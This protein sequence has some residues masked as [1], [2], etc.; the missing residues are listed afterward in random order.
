M[1]FLDEGTQ[2]PPSLTWA[3]PRKNRLRLEIKTLKSL[4]TAKSC[5]EETISKEKIVAY[6]HQNFNK[7]LAN[8]IELHLKFLEKSPQGYRYTT[9][10]KQFALTVYFLGPNVYRYL[11]KMFQ[12]P[13]TSTLY[14]ITRNWDISPGVNNLIFC[15]LETKI[16]TM[17]ERERNCIICMDE[18]SIK[19]FLFYNRRTDHIV[20]FHKTVI[21]KKVPAKSVFVIMARGLFSNWKQPLVY[22]FVDTICAEDIIRIL[23]EVVSRLTAMR[24]TVHAVVSD[25]GANFV[26]FTRI[27]SITP[28]HPFFF[29]EHTKLF[30]FFDIPHVLKST[31]NNFLKYNFATSGGVTDSKYVKDFYNRDKHLSLR[32]APKLTDDHMYPNSFKKMKV[33]LAAQLF[34]STVASALNTY[35][36][37]DALPSASFA[38]IRFT[39]NI[40][41]LF[42]LFNSSRVSGSKDFNRPFKGSEAQIKFLGQMLHEFSNMKVLKNY[43]EDVTK[44]LNFLTGW[45]VSINSLLGLHNNVKEKYS[46]LYTRRINQDCLEN[47]FGSLRQQS[48]N[49]RNPTAVQVNQGF[50]KLFCLNYFQQPNNTNC[51]EDF[52]SVL[53]SVSV[54]KMKS[55]QVVVNKKIYFSNLNIQETDYMNLNAVHKNALSYICGY[56]LRKCLSQHR[57]ET[58]DTYSKDNILAPHVFYTCFRAYE[59][60][61]KDVFGNLLT[62]PENFIEYLFILEKQFSNFFETYAAEPNC[63][64]KIKTHLEKNKNPHPCLQFPKEFFLSLYVCLKIHHVLKST[65]RTFK[66]NQYGKNQKLKNVKHL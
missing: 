27:N 1:Y 46:T 8:I 52:D 55:F 17:D 14:R 4:L 15:I 29:V 10:Y 44:K 37:L 61:H 66:E 9:E 41:R 16:Q 28:D 31:R 13:S 38:T 51:I 58:C 49:C 42:D 56:L 19:K 6:C 63:G 7:G 57:C 2:T 39:E 18:M 40:D 43:T 50:K 5:D 45:K 34:S 24:M 59:N 53:T 30:Y 33:K 26:R 3:S 35:M 36:A 12:L 22:Y 21:E 23:H 62:P 65:N 11:Q 20:G 25:Q 64:V 32:L 48:G 54:E 47:F 60:K